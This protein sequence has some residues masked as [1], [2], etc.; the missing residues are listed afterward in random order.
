MYIHDNTSSYNTFYGQYF[1][2][3]ITRVFNHA[4]IQKKS[5]MS[6]TEV[7]NSIWD[8]P[9]IYTNYLSYGTTTQQSNLITQDFA[10][11]ESTYSASFLGDQNSIGGLY[12]DVLKGNLIVIKFRAPN[13]TTLKTLT[14]INLYY[15]DSPFTNT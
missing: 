14:A 1:D 8:C 11:I 9:V 10:D 3:T 4:L 5:W 7:S 6:L 13:A 12:G 2:S 15:I